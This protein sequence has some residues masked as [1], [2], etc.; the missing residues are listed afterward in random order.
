MQKVVLKNIN[1]KLFYRRLRS[2]DSLNNK[3]DPSD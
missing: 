1:A 2:G 3:A